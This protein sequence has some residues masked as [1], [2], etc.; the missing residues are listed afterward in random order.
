MEGLI[1]EPLELEDDRK[2]MFVISKSS[3][4]AHSLEAF[5]LSKFQKAH[6]FTFNLIFELPNVYTNLKRLTIESPSSFGD[7][8][9]IRKFIKV[10]FTNNKILLQIFKK[11]KILT[12]VTTKHSD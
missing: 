6:I 4:N 3:K 9:F 2:Q 11:V 12:R 1:K 5:P 8:F 7:L 10:N